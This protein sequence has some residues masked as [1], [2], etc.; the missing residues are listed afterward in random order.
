MPIVVFGILLFCFLKILAGIKARQREKEMQAEIERRQTAVVERKIE[1]ARAKIER[2][3]ARQ[4]KEIEKHEAWLKKHDEEIAKLQYKVEKA[5]ADIEHLTEQIGQYYAMLD[6]L[7]NQR[8]IAVPGSKA[9]ASA[10]SKIIT[11]QN[12]IHTAETR[13]NKAKFDKEQAERKMAS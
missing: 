4:A 9:D 13:L 2:E 8:A 12:K 7:E 6:I 10:Q 5:E 3:Q 1:Q 11:M